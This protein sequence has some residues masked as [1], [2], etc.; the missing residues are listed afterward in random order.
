MT[1]HK[2]LLAV[3]VLLAAA[4]ALLL[5]T[6]RGTW[7]ET[8]FVFGA[9]LILLIICHVAVDEWRRYRGGQ[10]SFVDLA[11][12]D[13]ATLGEIP[14]P[15]QLGKLPKSGGDAATDRMVASG[16][17]DPVSMAGTEH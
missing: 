16:H 11:A 15:G 6:P 8:A 1:K 12:Y 2:G 5:P 14:G 10:G 4:I 7:V 3:A 9:A 17:G 13:G